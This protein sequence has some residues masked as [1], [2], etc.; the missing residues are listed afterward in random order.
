MAGADD[1]LVKG[2][3]LVAVCVVGVVEE[4]LGAI[5]S[6]APAGQRVI[7]AD[8]LSQHVEGG[9]H[10]LHWYPGGA[11]GGEDHALGQADEG[12]DRASVAGLRNGGQDGRAGDRGP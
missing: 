6:Q 12:N 9:S 4:E 10:S 11:D 7:D 5:G 1:E 8:V 2:A 3:G